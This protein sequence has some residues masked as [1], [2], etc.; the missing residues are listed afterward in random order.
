MTIKYAELFA[1]IGGLGAG[2]KIEGATCVFANEY[3]KY[4]AQ[5]YAANN[6]IEVDSRDVRT[7]QPQ[8]IPD[9]DILLAGFPC[10]PFSI[11]GISKRRS[12]GIVTGM[13]CKDQGNLFFEAARLI[14]AHRPKVVV[15]EN[16]KNLIN[17]D[18]GNT[19]QVIVNTLKKL[20][21]TVSVRLLNAAAW[22]PQNR[23]RV[24]IVGVK[25]G[26]PCELD[27]LAIP[28]IEEWPKL[29]TILH[30]SDGTEAAEHPYTYGEKHLCVSSKYVLT[31]HM[32]T[33]L[34]N[35][36]RKHQAKGNGFGF[37]LVK[38]SDSSRTLSAR[39]YKDG[40]EILIKRKGNPRRLTPRECA[41]LMGFDSGRSA[42]FKIP[43]SDNQAYKQFG[44][45]VVVPVSRTIATAVLSCL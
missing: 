33:Y 29:K 7:V 6:N 41:R 3:D 36:K 42:S 13:D 16:V 31:D 2:F 15:F 24:F 1:G 25:G 44:N 5:T 37:G 11:A 40:S 20:G 8:D 35:Y 45:A 4:A 19:Y 34:Q 39:Y 14:S 21:Y 32:W 22:V 12:L 18:R 23:Q 30:K 9:H 43:V 28:E 27:N 10:Q 26:N 38:P 17:H